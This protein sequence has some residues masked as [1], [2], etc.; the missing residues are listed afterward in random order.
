MKTFWTL[1]LS[2]LAQAAGNVMMGK[3]MQAVSGADG[4]VGAAWAAVREPRVIGGTA[5]LIVFFVLYA[6]TLSWADLSF[7]LPVSAFGYV[8][9]VAFARYF[10][11]ES[12]S[13]T[14]WAGTVLVC[15]GVALVARTEM[16]TA[17]RLRCGEHDRARGA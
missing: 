15:V 5:L 7:V 4:I 9:N 14:R 17:R 6:A 16:C 3:G 2:M 1:A 10:L 8:L 11:A 13:P 12:V